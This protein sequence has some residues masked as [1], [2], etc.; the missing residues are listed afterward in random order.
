MEKVDCM[1][2]LWKIRSGRFAGWRTEDGLLYDD[3]GAH[4]GYFVTS[5][6]QGVRHRRP[7]TMPAL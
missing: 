4:V 6:Q 7:S 2:P 5:Q 1:K 3:D